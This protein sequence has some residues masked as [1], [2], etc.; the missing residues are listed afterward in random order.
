[1]QK[2][3]LTTFF[4]SFLIAN[5]LAQYPCVNGISTNPANPVNTQLPS[6][7]NTFFDW[8][9]STWKE[10]PF[11]NQGNCSREDTMTSPFFRTDNAEELR[12]SKDMK[13]DDGW[14]LILRRVGL[15]EQNINTPDIDPD[16]TVILYNK[17]TGILRSCL[18][19]IQHNSY[20]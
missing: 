5:S 13:W 14:E 12:D 11:L 19:T 9:L 3:L 16:I 7:V 8:Q 20:S 18:K 2:Y 10:K 15:N 4:V 17:Y 6:K 1:M